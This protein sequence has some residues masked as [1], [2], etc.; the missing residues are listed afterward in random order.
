MRLCEIY[1]RIA[2]KY[3]I[4]TYIDPIKNQPDQ[5]TVGEYSSPMGPPGF[6]EGVSLW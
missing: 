6:F 5:C 1:I 3:G 4:V 2:S